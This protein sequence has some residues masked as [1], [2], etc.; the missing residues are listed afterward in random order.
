MAVK[1]CPNCKRYSVSFDFNR[2]REVCRWKDCGWVNV[3]HQDLPTAHVTIL[4]PS[5]IQKAES[6]AI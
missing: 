2:G 6:E 3:E 5:K 1:Q 4:T